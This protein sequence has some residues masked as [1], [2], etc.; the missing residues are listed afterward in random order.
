VRA[1]VAALNVYP[2]KSCRGLAADRAEVTPDGL[3]IQ[4]VRDREWM[5][6]DARGRFVTQREL[7]RL[8]L[9]ATEAVNGRMQLRVP[10]LEPVVPE[11]RGPVRDVVVW[12]AHLRGRDGGNAAADA[13]SAYLGHEVRL[14]R[15][16]DSRPRTVNPDFAGTSGATTLYSD[17]YPLL[18]IGQ[19][20]LD[21]LNTRLAARSLA[22]L[23]MNR[24]RPNVVV[25]GLD[26]YDEDHIDTLAIGDVVLK[27]VKPCTR[28]EITTTDQ[29]TARR[30]QEPL[31]TLSMYRRDD[32]LAGVTFG[33]N[34][35]VA[36]GAG[37]TI[38]VGNDAQAT[39]KF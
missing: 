8:A 24:F 9:V 33:M 15:F 20:S 23:P 16:D 32:R 12:S 3:A 36:Q 30:S 7:P 5:I 34:A 25:D 2:V 22:K 29:E 18:V 31:R 38:V 6:V 39:L 13:L 21:D 4:G 19:A 1:T 26:P 11:E 35:I 10:G 14:V 17:G 27:L 37:S 28:C